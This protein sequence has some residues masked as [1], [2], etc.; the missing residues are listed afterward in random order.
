MNATGHHA[1]PFIIAI[2]YLSFSL[3]LQACTIF[4]IIIHRDDCR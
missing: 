2:S 3:I 4:F 1:R